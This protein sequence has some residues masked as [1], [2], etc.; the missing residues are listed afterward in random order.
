MRDLEALRVF[1]TPRPGHYRKFWAINEL[2]RGGVPK[3]GIRE[4]IKRAPWG[5]ESQ[6]KWLKNL[7][8]LSF[9]PEYV[10]PVRVS[11]VEVMFHPELISPCPFCATGQTESGEPYE[12]GACT[13]EDYVAS[14]PGSGWP[15]PLIYPERD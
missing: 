4:L 13:Y 10:P 14:E 12:I 15:P 7:A 5:V 6:E 2:M 9:D 1:E 11:V 3:E 8:S